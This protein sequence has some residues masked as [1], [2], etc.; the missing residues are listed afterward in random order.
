MGPGN[1]RNLRYGIVARTT[2]WMTSENALN[3]EPQSFEGAMLHD[4]L[5]H[6]FRAC[7][8]ESA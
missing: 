7:R 6:V 5:T 2:P 4:S 1:S 8:R 3:T